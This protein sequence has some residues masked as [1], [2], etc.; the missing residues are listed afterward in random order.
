VRTIQTR[1][2]KGWAHMGPEWIIVGIVA[3]LVLFGSSKIPKLARGMGQAK[4]EFEAGL[5]EG[6][7]PTDTEETK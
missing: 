4:K 7:K 5:K 2:E 6:E 3:L 1:P